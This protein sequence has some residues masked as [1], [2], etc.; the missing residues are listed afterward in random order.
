MFKAEFREFKDEA[1][2]LKVF[3]KI[4]AH[5]V[6]KPLPDGLEK[7]AVPSV[8]DE[9]EYPLT[10]VEVGLDLVGAGLKLTPTSFAG[11]GIRN[12]LFSHCGGVNLRTTKDA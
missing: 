4:E 5:L 7:Y 11:M 2:L 6:D 10:T 8:S 1:S 9:L 12:C 3:P